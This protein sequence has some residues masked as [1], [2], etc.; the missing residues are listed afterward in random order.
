MFFFP[1]TMVVPPD[2]KLQME[3]SGLVKTI[4][5]PRLLPL[6]FF[7]PGEGASSPLNSP[8]TRSGSGRRCRCCASGA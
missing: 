2:A 3:V 8:R 6:K 4:P 5:L 7:N 1:G